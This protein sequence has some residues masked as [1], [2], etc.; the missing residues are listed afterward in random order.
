MKTLAILSRKGG[1]GKTTLA[2]H[3]AVIAETTGRRVLLVDCDPQRSA[4]RWYEAREAQTPLLVAAEADKLP[5]TLKAAQADKIDLVI[6]DSRP[7]VERDTALI[8][9]EAS[10]VLIP[11]RPSVLDLQAIGGTIEV[12]KLAKRP[13]AIVLNACPP[14]R[15]FGESAVAHD[16]RT[17]LSGYQS[18]LVPVSITQ[19]VALANALIDGRAVNELEPSGK[20][21]R[22]MMQLWQFIEGKLWRKQR[23]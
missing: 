10:F 8:A 1:A 22:E 2:I 17:M 13:S 14:A 21:A 11:T 20:A 9:G 15:L 6:V 4:T 7:S 18:E 12:V 5:A 23:S 16:A 3:L 19:R